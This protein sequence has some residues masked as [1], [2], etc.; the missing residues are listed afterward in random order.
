MGTIFKIAFRNTMRHKRR[1]FLTAIII[2]MGLFIFIWFDSLLSGMDR[3]SIENMVNLTESSIKVYSADY[4]QDRNA[5]PLKYGISNYSQIESFLLNTKGVTGVTPRTSFLGELTSGPKALH[6]IGT[7]IDPVKDKTVFTTSKYIAKGRYFSTNSVTEILLGV[8][9]ADDM[10]VNVGDTITL[11]S[12]TKFEANNAVDFEVVGLINSPHPA[13]NESGAYITYQAAEP[14]LDIG[15]I[16]PEADIHVDWKKGESADDYLTK[17]KA[18]KNQIKQNFPG[19][20]SYTFNDLQGGFL[21]LLKQKGTS[22]NIMSFLI[23]LIAAIGIVN[24]VLMSV[25]ERIR[26]VGVLKAMGIKPAEILRMFMYEGIII[27]LIGSLLGLLLAFITNVW[28]VTVGMDWSG[29][30]KGASTTSMGMPVSMVFYGQ[31]NPGTFI[32]MFLFGMIISIAAS[33]VPARKA[34]KMQATD[35]LHFV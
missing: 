15:G 22:G 28:M 11:R 12:Q 33:Y 20:A 1:T 13:V 30:M 6:V 4:D 25:Y 16:Y 8:K 29:M 35:C 34:A 5:L 31:W 26:E 27:G 2:T 17:L 18:L 9:L 10:K 23:L 21:A 7:I 19:V 24:S 3:N 32:G 14:F